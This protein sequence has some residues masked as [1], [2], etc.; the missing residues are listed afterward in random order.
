MW[1]ELTLMIGKQ[2]VGL[3]V[4]RLGDEALERAAATLAWMTLE[5]EDAVDDRDRT[6]RQA[7]Y[8]KLSDHIAFHVPED[9]MASL[10]AKWWGQALE[11]A[12][13]EFVRANDLGPR[14]R[15][16]WQLIRQL[17]HPR[18]SIVGD[19]CSPEIVS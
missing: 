1:I 14:V 13:V 7:L 9:R 3:S 19:A 11:R 10:G 4:E 5:S 12:L 18:A 17:Q 8:G 2:R 16:H 6:I 15:H